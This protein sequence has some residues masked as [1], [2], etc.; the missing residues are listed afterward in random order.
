M[1]APTPRDFWE[2]IPS[3]IRSTIILAVL[4]LAVTCVIDP[5]LRLIFSPSK[6]EAAHAPAHEKRR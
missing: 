3:W 4:A 6:K 2:M 5:A 1:I